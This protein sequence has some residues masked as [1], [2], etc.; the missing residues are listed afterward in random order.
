MEISEPLYVKTMV[1][2]DGEQVP[3]LRPVDPRIFDKIIA[4]VRNEQTLRRLREW[5]SADRKFTVQASLIS[6]AEKKVTLQKENGETI[7]IDINQLSK[8][9]RDYCILNL[10]I[11]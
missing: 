2:L 3:E 8:S 9:D 1:V 10:G 5:K 4:E 7:E 11:R 6:L